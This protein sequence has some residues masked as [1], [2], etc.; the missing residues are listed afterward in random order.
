[1]CPAK[2]GYILAYIYI[3]KREDVWGDIVRA[4]LVM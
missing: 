3:L 1:M 2:K 4:F